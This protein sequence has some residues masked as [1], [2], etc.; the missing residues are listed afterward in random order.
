MKEKKRMLKFCTAVLFQFSL[1]AVLT[2]A[3]V[4][5]LADANLIIGAFV[6]LLV[7]V[8]TNEISGEPSDEREEL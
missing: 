2:Y 3:L 7:G 5:G 1:L 4:S 8:G 6:G